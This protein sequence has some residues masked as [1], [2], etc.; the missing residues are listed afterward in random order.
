MGLR[1]L[2]GPSIARLKA[3]GAGLFKSR[4]PYVRF[5][6]LADIFGANRDVRQVPEVDIHQIIHFGAN[7]DAQKLAGLQA[8]LTDRGRAEPRAIV[9]TLRAHIDGSLRID[10]PVAS[11]SVD[12]A[13]IYWAA[14]KGSVAILI[15]T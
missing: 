6:S 1:R 12:C 3:R 9:Q 8:S 2:V 7:D 14:M 10:A 13:A 11:T 15:R 4:G 5:G